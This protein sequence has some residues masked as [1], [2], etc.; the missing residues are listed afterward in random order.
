MQKSKTSF[1]N[2]VLK[3][4]GSTFFKRKQIL[5]ECIEPKLIFYSF[6]TAR[7]KHKFN[8]FL[9]LNWMIINVTVVDFKV[10]CSFLRYNE[11]C[12]KFQLPHCVYWMCWEAGGIKCVYN[13]EAVK[14]KNSY[15]FL[16]LKTEAYNLRTDGNT[17]YFENWI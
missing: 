1:L 11:K 2:F 10:L 12:G 14:N 13:I 3:V 9:L 4:S 6:T 15:S 5:L 7:W 17:I 16:W 8:H